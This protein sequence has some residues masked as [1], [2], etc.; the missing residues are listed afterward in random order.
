MKVLIIAER[1]HPEEFIVNDLA[2][3]WAAQGFEV[4]VLTQAPSY[5]FGKVFAGYSNR[6]WS[7]ERWNNVDIFRVFTVT[8]YRE[9]L[10]KKLL[11]YFYFAAA[12][13]VAALAIGGKYDRVFVYDTGPLT[14][15]LPAVF[16]R[17]FRRKDVTFWTQDVW[18]DMVYAYGFKKTP[19]M[20]FFL[21]NLVRLIYSGSDRIFISCEGF[22]ARVAPY[23]PG[24]PIRWFP[25][26]PTVTPGEGSDLAPVDLGPGFHFTFAGNVGKLQ[27]LPNILRGFAMARALASDIRLNIVG[28]GSA[29]AE[30]KETAARENIPGVVFWGRKKRTEMPGFFRASDAMI[31]SLQDDPIFA[32]TVP[33][34]FQAYLA[35][36]KPIFAVIKGDVK[37]M[38]ERHGVGLYAAPESP[39][40]IRD[41]FLK[42]R[43][44]PPEELEAFSIKSGE[45]LNKFYDR[46]KI[47]AGMTDLMVG[48][49]RRAAPAGK[50]K[51]FHVLECGD[52]SGCG[53][54]VASIC[55]GLDPARFETAVV[56]AVRPGAGKEAFEAQFASHVR[57][58]HLPAMV[59]PISPR[60]DLAAFLELKRLFS[61]ENPDAVHLHSSKAGFLGRYAARWAG[62]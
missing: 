29:L 14:M 4:D 25:N 56:Y 34:K 47:I 27:N 5:P 45:L 12:G 40:S 43:K 38:V 9:S 6:L 60:K 33:A 8:G 42:F 30:L 32:A 15:A 50:I 53:R 48:A 61:R 28:D 1:F 24:K 2:Q 11:G 51:I 13:S 23:A 26:W 3:E 62:V 37:D 7:R 59:R 31:V 16:L 44:M 46:E 57:K 18:P 17:F 54:L 55:N 35:F 58:I 41:G 52:L 20:E 36:S 39:E 19:L 10:F 22:R 21:D 49:T